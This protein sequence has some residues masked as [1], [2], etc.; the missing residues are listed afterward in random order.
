M[1][2]PLM[3][4]L[5]SINKDFGY[6]H[7]VDVMYLNRSDRS[8]IVSEAERLGRMVTD[9]SCILLTEDA[10]G[11]AVVDTAQ[12][13]NDRM[14]E[15]SQPTAMLLTRL[16]EAYTVF[17]KASTNT[18]VEE[19]ADDLGTDAVI[20]RLEGNPRFVYIYVYSVMESKGL[21]YLSKIGK[22]A[23][24]YNAILGH[25]Q[26]EVNTEKQQFLLQRL[27]LQS[28]EQFWIRLFTTD[29]M[30][31]FGS[32]IEPLTPNVLTT[33][34]SELR[35]LGFYGFVNP[36]YMYTEF[37]GARVNRKTDV[38]VSPEVV[39]YLRKVVRSGGVEVA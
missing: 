21:D 37:L 7:P 27:E 1:I 13:I 24:V 18:V 14:I 3:L 16:R 23:E 15:I 38:N 6:D 20:L 30:R 17:K 29:M 31:H 12:V 39:T 32:I 35:N 33:V 22:I 5:S 9:D 10:F 34:K 36:Y 25:S 11:K 19:D 28:T 2:Q 26:V 4:L 8:V